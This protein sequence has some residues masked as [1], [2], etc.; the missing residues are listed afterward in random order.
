MPETITKYPDISL[1]ILGKSGMECGTGAAQQILT[2]CPPERFCS[3]P[4]GEIC[5]YGLEEIPQMT[6][7]STHDVAE[8]VTAPIYSTDVLTIISFALVIGVFLGLILSRIL[9]K[10]S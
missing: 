10:R 2:A 3:S 4:V 8:A 5:V 6:Q 9:D 7:I 1:E